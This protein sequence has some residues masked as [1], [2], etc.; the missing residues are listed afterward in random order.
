M[1]LAN[2]HINSVFPTFFFVFELG[3]RRHRQTDRRTDGRA[4]GQDN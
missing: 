3:A 1:A 4:G 2:V